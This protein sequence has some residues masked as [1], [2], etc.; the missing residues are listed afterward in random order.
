M[1]LIPKLSEVKDQIASWSPVARLVFIII[2]LLISYLILSK[3]Y[4][5]WLVFD[6][7]LK[8]K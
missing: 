3:A 8:M 7:Y 6:D 1:A 2:L 5:Y 4:W